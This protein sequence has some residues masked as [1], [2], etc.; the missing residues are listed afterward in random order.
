MCIIY[1][2]PVNVRYI[3][4]L[5]CFT[6]FGCTTAIGQGH[7]IKGI[8]YEQNSTE[9]LS[10]ATIT[11]AKK[12]SIL[13]HI[14]SDDKGGFTSASLL[15]GKYVLQISFLGFEKLTRQVQV[16]DSDRNIGNIYLQPAENTLNEVKIVEKI[17]AVV[18]KDDT[19]EYNAGAYKTNPD[20]SAGDM[21]RKM[22]GVEM[23]G[24]EV[25]AQG[26]RVVKV[27]VDGRPFFG[28]D[29]Y[30]TLNNLPADIIDKVQ[31]YNEKSEQ[32]QF[33]GFS[34]G[35][36]NKTI[37][38]VTKKNKRQ[39]AFGKLSAAGGIDED[40]NKYF[41]G[42]SIHHFNNDKRLS[43]VMQTNNINIQNFSGQDMQDGLHAEGSG[44]A[45]IGSG[46]LNYTGKWGKKVDV[47]GSYFL[48]SNN[49]SG[50]R[51]TRRTYIQSD[52]GEV[53][54]E[55]SNYSSQ[56]YSHRFS[57]RIN[58]EIDS[59][60]SLL[61]QPQ[62]SVLKNENN[63]MSIASTTQADSLLN[64]TNN[65]NDLNSES[66]NFTS[67]I[68]FRH[69]FRKR[70][71]TL[72]VNIVTGFNNHDGNNMLQAEN[73]FYS[74]VLFN[75]T[76]NQQSNSE[77]RSNTLSCNINYTEPLGKN[78]RLLL[79]YSANQNVGNNDK[80]TYEYS[81]ALNSYSIVDT[82]LSNKLKS[83]NIQHKLGGSYQYQQ[84]KYEFSAGLYYQLSSLLNEQELPTA[85]RY[86]H[87][88]NNLQPVASFEYK[89]N[90]NKNIHINYATSTAIPSV[91]QLQ[92]VV[93]N[94][95]PLQLSIG[96][97]SLKQPYTNTITVR[98]MAVDAKKG[99]N[100]SVMIN[101][102]T[103][104]NTIANSTIVAAHDTT[105]FG[106]VFLPQGSVLSRP[107]NINGYWSVNGNVSYGIPIKTIKSNLNFNM[108]ANLSH[109][110]SIVNN[111][112]GNS[113]KKMIAI[114]VSLTSNIN[115]NVDFNI[116][117]GTNVARDENSIN[118]S[119][120]NTYLSQNAGFKF[121]WLSKGG[122]IF[123]SE[124]NYQTNVGS[125]NG[126]NREYTLCNLGIGYKL[127]KKRMGEIKFTAFD[128]FNENSSIQH[129]VT[130]TYISDTRSNILQ[131]YYLLTF[132]YKIRNFKN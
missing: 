82:N 121:N 9:P 49:N 93:N 124:F 65:V 34:E 107:V 122:F 97:S 18:Q 129:A 132:S 5:L 1:I 7:V 50:F 123:Y 101:G 6:V 103:V 19:T 29:P 86:S 33:T 96:N 111:E 61:I 125:A 78:S 20:A 28:N 12:D 88:F 56:A 13:Q 22:P 35:Q 131:R 85:N 71:R 77:Q 112:T 99:T 100:L 114:G 73:I 130:E 108:N 14:V 38:I 117:S 120:N 51:D 58:Y 66:F 84:K 102:S 32:E 48:T 24:T 4:L 30:A 76:L 80:K 92:E 119:L 89:F 16:G 69:K 23:N 36:T 68:L 110:P 87:D 116:T 74:S 46:G 94:T 64:S 26:E 3:L 57:L 75:D 113:E 118:T 41:I 39:G 70:G 27:I 115:E 2:D 59:F 21:V 47:T 11:I 126:F 90:A 25:K 53:Y 128:V 43:L 37:N 44:L 72:S 52:S 79:Q 45:K 109:V 98:Y 106:N 54:N 63:N 10:G 40:E 91:M 17:L 95:N 83:T 15:P 104:Q 127:F 67:N 62:L 42:G 55:N 8:V 31:V 105:V 60:N 81:D